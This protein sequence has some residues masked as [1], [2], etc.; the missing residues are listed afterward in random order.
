MAVRNVL[1]I[2]G[3]S[4]DIE[5]AKGWLER[6][7]RA[8]ITYD[9]CIAADSGLVSADK[10]GVTVDYMLGDYDSV[11]EDVLAKYQGNVPGDRY[12]AE[13]D[14][15]DTELAI[16]TALDKI[17]AGN[18]RNNPEDPDEQSAALHASVTVIGATG[19]RLD[20]TLANIGLLEQ[21]EREGVDGYIVDAHNMIRMLIMPGKDMVKIS[22]RGQFG[23][24]VSCIALTPV[25]HGL[26]MK[27]FKYPLDNHDLLQGVSLCVSNEITDEEGEISLKEGKMLVLETQD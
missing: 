11:D 26:T 19:T 3:G 13:K 12:P 4:V 8:G 24:Y 25:V 1:I 2:T 16:K 10:I 15:T 9:Y 22:S 21:I 27:G 6:Q 17:K 23:G 18:G 20:H 5:W 14:Y 7:K